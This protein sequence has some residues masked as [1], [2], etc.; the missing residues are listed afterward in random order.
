MHFRTGRSSDGRAAPGTRPVP[1]GLT[2]EQIKR[3]TKPRQRWANITIVF[4]FITVVFL[5]L[6]E[7]GSTYNRP[8]LRDWYFIRIDLSNIVPASVPNYNLINTIAQSLGLHDFY[9]VGLWGFCSGYRDQGVTYCSPPQTMYWFNPVEILANELLAGASI[10]LPS[11][12]NDILDLIRIASHVMFAFYL[13]SAI[14]STVLLFFVR[15]ATRSRLYS[16]PIATFCIIN[17]LL[18]IVASV[19]AT[20]MFVI[21]RNVISGVAELNISSELGLSMF[22]FM[23]IA[24]AFA[25][26]TA[27][28]HS[29]LCCCGTSR[30]D[31]RTGRKT[32]KLKLLSNTNNEKAGKADDRGA[33][34][35]V[36]TV[37]EECQ[38]NGTAQERSFTSTSNGACAPN[39]PSSESVW[40]RSI[41]RV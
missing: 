35:G 14:L 13:T 19:I 15:L 11:H 17:A 23:W 8:V 38:A 16:L 10:N 30:R 32:R 7:I 34:G 21:F 31:I 4:L 24:S 2:N 27:L 28:I 29:G 1:E 18:V 25:L 22:V 40:K 5:I 6:L 26:A 33:R 20:A 41:R 3:A 9:Q 36:C 39:L 12:I 37:D